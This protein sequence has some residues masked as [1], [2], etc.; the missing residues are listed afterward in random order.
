MPLPIQAFF[1]PL[2]FLFFSSRSLFSP[3]K[4]LLRRRHHR[5]SFS[6]LPSSSLR[7]SPS[8]REL[9]RERREKRRRRKTP[10]LYPLTRPHVYSKRR[11]FSPPIKTRLFVYYVFFIFLKITNSLRD[12]LTYR[13]KDALMFLC[14]RITVF[15]FI[16]T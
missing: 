7:R 1:V 9:S 16:H 14:F 12:G 8:R 4:K 11:L 2:L 5:G 6:P 10:L 13:D 3:E 15:S